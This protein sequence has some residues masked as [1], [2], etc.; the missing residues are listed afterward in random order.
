MPLLR[1]IIKDRYHQWSPQ[2]DPQSMSVAITIF[3][4]EWFVLLG[5]KKWRVKIVITT[6]RDCGRPRGS[7]WK[8]SLSL[9]HQGTNKERILTGIETRKVLDGIEAEFENNREK[10]VYDHDWEV[11]D[12]IISD[13]L[14]LGHMASPE[15][16]YP[17]EQVGLRIMHRVTIA[18]K[19]TPTK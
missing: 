15:T 2:P 11:G 3:T 17:V 14:A 19:F 7:M 5:F 16:Q 1:Y 10:L 4:W 9:L 18:G 12:F 13:N 6:G 8:S